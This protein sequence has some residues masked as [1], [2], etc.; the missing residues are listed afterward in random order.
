[1]KRFD[2]FEPKTLDETVAL[3][4]RHGGKANLLAGGTDLLVEIKEH[5]RQPDYVINIKKIPGLAELGYDPEAGLRFGA[6]V[7]AREIETSSVVQQKYR[8]LYLATR[9]LGSIQVRNRATITGNICRASPSADTL[10]PLIA[11][12]ASVSIHGPDGDRVVLLEKFFT[13]PGQTVLTPSELVTE[14]IV[15]APRLRT[16]KTYIKHGRRKAMELATV[17]V[18]V[19]LTLEGK[20]CREVRIALGAVAPTPIRATQ[21]E[22]AL[23]GQ[24]VDEQLIRVS[25]RTA[26][27]ESHPISNLRGSAEYRRQMVEV[28]TRRALR[29]AMEAAG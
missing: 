19:S 12:G 27:N 24:V 6:L 4:E 16:G 9:E 5:V 18:A 1:M 2:Y 15:P 28:L 20:T 17:G 21:A 3:L 22:A 23:H 11:D 14:I 8:G 7:T 10:P 13:G 25:A 26:M 29:Q